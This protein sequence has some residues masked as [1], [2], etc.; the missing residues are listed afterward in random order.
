LEVGL[1]LYGVLGRS[2]SRDMQMGADVQNE[3]T[4]ASLAVCALVLLRGWNTERRR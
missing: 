4:T 1:P 2:S 3:K